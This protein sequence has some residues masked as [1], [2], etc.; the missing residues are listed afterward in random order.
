MGKRKTP[1]VFENPF[2]IWD[3]EPRLKKAF[4]SACKRMGL[5]MREATIEFMKRYVEEHPQPK[6]PK[7]RRKHGD[8]TQQDSEIRRPVPAG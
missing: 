3:V 5:T 8:Q 7:S 2:H 1:Q 6:S 4:K